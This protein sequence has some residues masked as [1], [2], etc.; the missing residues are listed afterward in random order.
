MTDPSAGHRWS[1]L[2]ELARQEHG[3]RALAQRLL[4]EWRRQ[5]GSEAVALFT[6][7]DTGYERV[8]TSGPGAFPATLPKDTTE[9]VAFPEGR[10]LAVPADDGDPDGALLVALAAALE[11]HRLRGRLKEQRFTHN[12]RGVELE[13]LYD[14]GLAIASTLDLDELAE[15]VLLRAVSLLDARRGALYLRDEEGDF[16]LDHTFGGEASEILTAG[17]AR[18]SALLAAEKDPDT[19]LLPGTHHLLAVPVEVDGDPRGLL[20]VGDKES[21]TGVG[22][23]GERDRRTL[24]LF[25]NQAAIALENAR[26]HRQ[27]LEKERLER[28]LDLAA[29]IQKRL[30][31]TRL[32]E[33]GRF[34]VLGWNRPARHVG[35]DYYDVRRLGDDR[36]IV[37]IADVAGKGMPAALL[38][39]TLHSALRLLEDPQGLAPEMI[40]RLNQHVAEASASNKFITLLLAE[41]DLQEGAVRY[42]NAG[43]NAALLVRDDGAVETLGSCGLPLG[44][45]PGSTYRVQETRLGP[46]DLLCLF[47]DGLTECE[48]PRGEEF[49][50]A[51]LAT[52]VR[53]AAHRPLSDLV[54]EVDRVT[55]E[56]CEGG[57]QA[58]DQTLVFVRCTAEPSSA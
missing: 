17:D 28:E 30:L 49:G 31:P 1:E 19:D 34:E 36:L 13:A 23:F 2:A 52:L 29:D 22:P 54:A 48:S 14:V 11:I 51:R 7:G 40:A 27:A 6:A 46:G 25:A 32:P 10:L 20:V 47:S 4:E 35:G 16:R 58:D 55:G 38:V 57:P 26:L 15:G 42:V 50:E 45:F 24:G 12:Y 44:A 3:D 33:T 21:R 37:V 39:S 18:L 9:G 41:I 53:D 5:R 56:F 43:H 8:L